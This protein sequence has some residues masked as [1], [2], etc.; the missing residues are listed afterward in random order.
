[1]GM[2]DEDY[3]ENKRSDMIYVSSPFKIGFAKDK[4]AHYVS[5]VF[6][7][8]ERSAF[9]FVNGE[10]VIRA[11]HKSKIQ[12]KAVV[13]TDEHSIKSVTIQS[14]RL[15]KKD[16][17]RPEKEFAFNLYGHELRAFIDFIDVA[18][19]MDLSTPRRMKLDSEAMSHLDLDDAVKQWIA[20]NPEALKEIVDSQLTS[21]D[22]VAVAYRKKQIE[23]FER[24][25]SD[26]AYFAKCL[27][28][29]R[30]HGSVEAVWQGFFEANRWIFGYGL[31]HLSI[32]GFSGVKLEQIVSGA[33]VATAGKKIDALM[34]TRGRVGSIA[35]I[36][37]KKH[38]TPLLVDKAYRSRAWAPS[39]ELSGAVAQ[40]LAS[41][42]GLERQYG[43]QFSM[44]DK[45]GNPSGEHAL[46]ARPR[47]VVVCGSLSEFM[48][49]HGVN[50]D[51][52]RS[53]ELYRRHLVSP[54]IVTYDELLERARLI[55]ESVEG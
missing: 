24:L 49:E 50:Q 31:F 13:T 18:T 52:F 10:I 23:V 29:K 6:D 32:E 12:V 35:L 53:F 42:D 5:R 55:V 48:T 25:L 38:T 20:S 41:V 1:M 4:D 33:A 22:V 9:D 54:D 51:K 16:G 30:F 36:E 3:I 21:G 11:T 40:M 34:R 26:E 2:E 45:Q 39:E 37:I 15:Y 46:I 43:E 47:S 19:K 7:D 8:A 27:A 28:D 14:F 44:K 17:W